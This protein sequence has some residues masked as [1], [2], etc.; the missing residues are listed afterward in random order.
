MRIRG[1]T[2]AILVGLAV[3]LATPSMAQEPAQCEADYTVEVGDWLSKIADRYYDD[4]S[5]YPPIV[6]ATNARATADDS[7]ATI[8]NPNLII[9][10]WKLCIPSADEARAALTL[11]ALRNAEYKSEWTKSGTAP[12]SRG[13][14]QE[15]I[16][17]GAA[18]KIN[19]TLTRHMAFG[20][21][22]DG[23][24]VAAVVLYTAPGGS[25]T[26]YDLAVVV[27][28]NGKLVNLATT[29]LGDRVK[30]NSLSTE[31]GEIVVDMI[32]HGPND[33][34]CCPTQRVLETYALE[35]NQ[36][37]KT[38]SKVIKPN[39]VATLW[40]WE[41]TQTPIGATVVDAPDKYTLKLLPDGKVD[42]KADCNLASGTYQIDGSHISI[43]ITITTLAACPEGSLG[44]QFIKDLNAAAIYFTEGGNLFIDL[45]FDS[46]TM[47]FAQ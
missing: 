20:Y 18:T 26:F 44:D 15:E 41:R 22:T 31:D 46:G 7:Y 28:Q 3:V 45:K 27:Q 32:T 36:L 17:P 21:L 35:D 19:V 9:P 34:M 5:L 14:Y 10:G 24:E 39:I 37:A 6:F 23:Q 4:Y 1:I 11:D 29:L 8:A 42:V 30:I 47:K 38:S 40:K 16:V 43:E 25:G 13:T 2:V 12:L 33:P